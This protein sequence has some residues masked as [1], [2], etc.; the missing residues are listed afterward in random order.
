LGEFE[1]ISYLIERVKTKFPSEKIL[2][3]F[4]SPSGFEIKKNFKFADAVV[5][6]P[7]DFK[8]DMTEF[9]SLIQ[10][11]LVFWVRYE[12]WLNTLTILKENQTQTYLLNGVFRDKISFFY[13]PILTKALACFTKIFVI[14]EQSSINLKSLGYESELLYDT[15]YDRMAQVVETPFEDKIIQEFVKHDKV[16]ICGSTWATDDEIISQAINQSTDKRWVIVPHE[17]HNSRISEL[18]K[19]YPRAQLYS[20]FEFDKT[21]HILIVDTIGFLSKIY[22]Y[23]DLVYVGGGFSKVV[24]SLIE[25]MAYSMPI[26]IGKNIAKSEEAIEFV[27]HKL[28]SQIKTSIEFELEVNRYFSQDNLPENKRK[29]KIFAYRQGSVEKILTIVEKYIDL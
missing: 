26:I 18:I 27:H 17:I 15:R 24:H 11:K 14:S 8:T 9:I 20:N 7:F 12:F 2:V 10:P 25:P 4:F 21:S 16:V 13:K 1:Q 23:A 22:R 6:L 5:Y 29:R 28:V 3:T 19:L